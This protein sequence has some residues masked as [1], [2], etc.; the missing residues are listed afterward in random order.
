VVEESILKI[1]VLHLLAS[2]PDTAPNIRHIITQSTNP[3]ASS[4]HADHTSNTVTHSKQPPHKLP[5]KPIRPTVPPRLLR[6]P[7]QKLRLLPI[8]HILPRKQIRRLRPHPHRLKP[9]L[10]S[11]DHPQIQRNTKVSGN[12]VLVVEVPV[13]VGRV[14]EHGVVLGQGDEDAEEDGAVGAVDA[15][16]RGVGEG[17]GGDVLR[18]AGAN[19]V[20]VRDEDGNPG[21]EAED[22]D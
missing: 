20:D 11:K 22:C 4:T 9:E 15:E 14:H 17:R 1:T 7:R 13:G 21:E 6:L 5:I 16:G 18:D 12:E 8:N 19:E 10:I 3:S 2:R